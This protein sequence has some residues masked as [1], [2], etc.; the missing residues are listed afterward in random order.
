MS[1]FEDE[2]YQWRETYF[3]LFQERNRPQAVAV[4]EGLRTLGGHYEIKNIKTNEEGQLLALT[5]YSAQDYSAM[6]INTLTGEEVIE[7]AVEL[8][9]Q[10]FENADEEERKVIGQFTECDARFDIYHFEQKTDQP[11]S[12]EPD[13]ILDPGS[14]LIVLDQLAQLCK[15]IGVDPQSGALMEG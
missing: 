2:S 3:V 5:I 15:G 13:E 14:L 7:H 1:L 8:A 4:V 12:G 11:S 6:D 9:S 10:M